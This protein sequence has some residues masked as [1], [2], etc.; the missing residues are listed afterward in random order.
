[1]TDPWPTFRVIR[2]K[3]NERLLKDHTDA[4]EAGHESM[5]S[6]GYM[7]KQGICIAIGAMSYYCPEPGKG[8]LNWDFIKEGIHELLNG[9][10]PRGNG[11][12]D[13]RDRYARNKISLLPATVHFFEDLSKVDD[14]RDVDPSQRRLWH[15]MK[16][17]HAADGWVSNREPRFHLFT[18]E[19]LENETEMGKSRQRSTAGKAAGAYDAKVID[20]A[21]ARAYLLEILRPTLPR[22]LEDLTGI[23]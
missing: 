4:I 10:S 13:V 3:G 19:H 14:L 6:K 12:D 15:P 17:G 20:K 7:W 9:P 16:C 8:Y 5:L 2:R 21:A 11:A 18:D 22:T 23:S 1:M